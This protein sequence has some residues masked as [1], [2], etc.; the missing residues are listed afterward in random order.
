MY[1]HQAKTLSFASTRPSGEEV[2]LA[3]GEG[4]WMSMQQAIIVTGLTERTLRRHIKR[5]SLKFRRQGKQRNSPLELWI[6]PDISKFV[7]LDSQDDSQTIEVFDV[8]PN[9]SEDNA[10]DTTPD[11]TVNVRMEDSQAS[12][13]KPTDLERV[14]ETI[15]GQFLKQLEQKNEML[16][17]LRTELQDKDRQLKLLPDLQKQAAERHD[18]EFKSIALEKQIEELKLLNENL[19][20][21]AATATLAQSKKSWW[22]SLFQ[23]G[24][25]VS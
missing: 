7:D 13:Q 3:V 11:A 15:T 22:K 4:R 6:T 14:L 21:A 16:Y 24:S 9:D 5:G 20:Q 17:E 23:S 25:S 12:A 1:S 2:R 10:F 18:A 19:Q 8:D